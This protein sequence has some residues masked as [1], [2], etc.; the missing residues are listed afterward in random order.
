MQKQSFDIVGMSCAACA[1]RIDKAVREVD[2]VNDCNV[3]L[4]KNRLTVIFDESKVSTE[5]KAYFKYLFNSC[6][7]VRFDGADVR[8][9]PDKRC[10]NK[11]F[12]PACADAIYHV[13]SA[14]LL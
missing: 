4:L 3:A 9:S 10:A 14:R 12:M 8:A 7:N 13:Y 5:K 1:A 2:G 6:P 11:R